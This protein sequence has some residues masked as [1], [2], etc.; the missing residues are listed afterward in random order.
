MIRFTNR[1]GVA[2]GTTTMR[3]AGLGAARTWL[4]P[5]QG[6]RSH[7]APDGPGWF[8]FVDVDPQA[9]IPVAG[10]QVADET[11]LNG[12][13]YYDPYADFVKLKGLGAVDTTAHIRWDLIGLVGGGALFVA[14]AAGLIANAFSR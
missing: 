2:P 7:C 10:P 1:V 14:M 3:F 8:P 9:P 11:M 5:M 13:R 4:D 6:Q 12:V